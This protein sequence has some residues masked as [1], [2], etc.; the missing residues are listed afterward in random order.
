V[1]F[2]FSKW[3][4]KFYL[5]KIRGTLALKG[6]KDLMAYKETK[7]HLANPDFMVHQARMESKV[8][9]GKMDS[10]GLLAYQAYLVK[11]A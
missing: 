2:L 7:D 10:Q 3:N 5:I 4:F 9:L 11:T 8:K 1:A 6:G